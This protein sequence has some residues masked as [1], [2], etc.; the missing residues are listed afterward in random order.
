MGKV[1]KVEGVTDVG[2][3]R[4]HNEDSFGLFPDYNLFV[5]AD[6][7]GGHRA[8][9]VASSL[10]IQAIGEFFD[11]TAKDDITWPFQFDPNSPTSVNRFVTSI[12]MGNSRIFQ[13]S[14]QSEEHQGMG[15]TVVGIM[16]IENNTAMH[17]AHVGDSRC[18]RIRNGEIAAITLD[19]SLIND[20]LRAA[21][22]LTEEQLAELPSNVITRALGMQDKVLV[23]VQTI[24]IETGDILLLCSDGLNGMLKDREILQIVETNRAT[25]RQAAQALINGANERGGEDNITVI[26]VE[27][28]QED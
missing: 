18:Y 28:V 10:A 13:K 25:L 6:G 15:T 24:Q 7:M 9:D 23:D 5:V 16:G 22:D 3:E 14:N 26:L 19:H 11:A 12:Q 2:R 4:D 1:L 8:G 17:V 27:V 20:Y 21:P